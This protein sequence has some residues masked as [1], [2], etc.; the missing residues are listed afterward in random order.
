MSY[1]LD[2]LGDYNIIRDDLKR[3]GGSVAKL[4]KAVGD[5]AVNRQA[6]AI[7]RKGVLTGCAGTAAVITLVYGGYEGIKY[8][9]GR[10]QAVKEEEQLKVIFEA[11]VENQGMESGVEKPE[12]ELD[13]EIQKEGKCTNGKE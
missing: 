5:N 12:S 13:E 6:P 8:W 7:F 9:L 10:R 11:T 1:P 4:Y 3:M 2:N